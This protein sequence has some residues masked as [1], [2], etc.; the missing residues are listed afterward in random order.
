M[1]VAI[2]LATLGL[3]ALPARA[4]PAPVVMLRPAQVNLAGAPQTAEVWIESAP[5]V[6]G[7]QLELGYDASLVAVTAVDAG[8]FLSATGGTASLTPRF[9]EPGRLVLG[10]DVT[11]SEDITAP[12][13]VGVL[14]TVTFAPLAAGGPAPLTL[15]DVSLTGAGGDTIT[16]DR[17]VGGEVVVSVPPPAAVQTETVAQ[18]TAM[19]ESLEGGGGFVP[20][21]PDLSSIGGELVWLGLLAMALA[22]VVVGWLVGRRPTQS[23]DEW[24]PPGDSP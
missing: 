17:T 2:V 18:A 7:F 24:E 21:L 1:F 23:R 15:R 14:A 9:A 19:A 20:K 22:V 16:V 12:S 10:A 6:V 13:G 5:Q 11:L 3:A 8:A 4:Q